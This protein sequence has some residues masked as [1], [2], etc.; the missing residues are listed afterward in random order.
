MVLG[1]F[2]PHPHRYGVGHRVQYIPLGWFLDGLGPVL[3]RSCGGLGES[4]G[5]PAAVLGDL[6]KG[7][8]GVLA[9][10]FWPPTVWTGMS[11]PVH[12]V[13]AVSIVPRNLRTGSPHPIVHKILNFAKYEMPMCMDCSEQTVL[14][15]V[16]WVYIIRISI[17]MSVDSN[18]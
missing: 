4:W 16:N 3:G 13:G 1:G 9:G 11:R 12:T 5:G 15:A 7:L 14:G 8:G 17:R 2:W 10:G 6:G 18:H